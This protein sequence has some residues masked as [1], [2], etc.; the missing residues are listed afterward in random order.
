MFHP[1]HFFARINTLI[2]QV[3]RVNRLNLITPVF[4]I[5][6]YNKGNRRDLKKMISYLR[7]RQTDRQT[8]KQ[9]RFDQRF[10]TP[11]NIKVAFNS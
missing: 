10:Y 2:K 4:P 3:C 7:H 6:M 9:M 11:N 8:D 5:R 1:T